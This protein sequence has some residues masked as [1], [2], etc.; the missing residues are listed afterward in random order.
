MPHSFIVCFHHF[1]TVLSHRYCCCACTCLRSIINRHAN[2]WNQQRQPK[3][4]IRE[5]SW[6]TFFVFFFLVS[7][8]SS[9]L[10]PHVIVYS[11]R[12]WKPFRIFFM[13][14]TQKQWANTNNELW[15]SKKPHAF[16]LFVVVYVN[17]II[18]CHK[19]SL[20][21]TLAKMTLSSFLL[22]SWRPLF[23]PVFHYSSFQL[24]K[25]VLK[26]RRK[27]VCFFRMRLDIITLDW[28]SL[29]FSSHISKKM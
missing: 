8:F 7:L 3:S 18:H 6:N 2:A 13:T 26:K 17:F 1:I 5:M 16:C 23:P 11:A 12:I 27:I 15:E 24:E 14:T 22:H 20:A 4:R 10:L 28:P 25:Y 9:L 19:R 21:V 29:S